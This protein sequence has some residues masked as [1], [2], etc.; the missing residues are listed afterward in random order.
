M[1]MFLCLGLRPQQLRKVRIFTQNGQG[2]M[3]LKIKEMNSHRTII[4]YIPKS[5]IQL[6]IFSKAEYPLTQNRLCRVRDTFYETNGNFYALRH[7]HSFNFID[8]AHKVFG[9]I[10]FYGAQERQFFTLS[11]QMISQLDNTYSFNFPFYQDYN[12]ERVMI[13]LIENKEVQ[14]GQFSQTV[15]LDQN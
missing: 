8:A 13:D 7:L 14:I 1:W 11:S 15:T 2:A 10:Y 6:A 5:L 12:Q 9:N 3:Y 4:R